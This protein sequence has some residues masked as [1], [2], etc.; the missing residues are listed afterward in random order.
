MKLQSKIILI[1]IF[2]LAV[3]CQKPVTTTTSNEDGFS[4]ENDISSNEVISSSEEEIDTCQHLYE[5]ISRSKGT[6]VEPGVI[7]KK[8]LRCEKIKEF[9]LYDLDEFVFEDQSFM[10]DGNAHEL[11]IKGMI[12]YGTTVEY[13]NYSL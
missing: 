1:S 10:Y 3:S 5:E 7:A 12:P 6:I 13:E 2:A 9:P 8:C 11:L 4:S